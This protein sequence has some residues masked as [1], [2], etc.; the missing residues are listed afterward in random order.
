MRRARERIAKRLHGAF[1]TSAAA[2]GW[3]WPEPAVTYAN[4]RLPQALILAGEAMGEKEMLAKGL[5]VLRWL[6][7]IQ[8]SPSGW[9][10]PIGN[11]GWYERGK[12]KAQF[13][14]Q[15]TEAHDMVEACLTAY[16]A[17]HE[18]AWLDHARVAFEWFLGRNDILMPLYDPSSGG[19]RDGLHPDR[20]NENQGS[21]STL[22][23]LL[24]LLR[25]HLHQRAIESDRPGR[26]R[27]T[28]ALADPAPEETP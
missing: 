4:A 6:V 28:P 13:D 24:A 20:P 15:P 23:W 21:E 18:A 5:D 10:S 17:T 2:D 9:F 3:P 25:I 19:C 7:R 22:A 12:P 1:R 14:Q 26:S 16:G 27:R 8:R 11:Q